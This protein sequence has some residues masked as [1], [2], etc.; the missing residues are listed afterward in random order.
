MAVFDIT[1]NILDTEGFD[2]LYRAPI[3]AR[4]EM[5]NLVAWLSEHVGTFYG[6]GD[7]NIKRIGSGWEIFA[8][9]NGKTEA[10]WWEDCEV[11]WYVDITDEA[12]S[13]L[14]ALK[15]TK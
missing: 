15:W 10:P 9:Y 11:K 4:S 3:E 6:A 7:K 5:Q 12:K 13:T 2:P 1:D 8:L 14:F